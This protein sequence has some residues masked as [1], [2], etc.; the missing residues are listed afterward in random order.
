VCL[1]SVSSSQKKLIDLTFLLQPYA[2][3]TK[4][5]ET[6]VCREHLE[7]ASPDKNTHFDLFC[8]F[9]ILYSVK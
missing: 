6:L 3:Q 2:S 8:Y 1:S 9:F 5:P 4:R 7:G